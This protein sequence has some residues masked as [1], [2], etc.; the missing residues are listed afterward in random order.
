[1]ISGKLFF[2]FLLTLL[3]ALLL[4]PVETG[5]IATGALIAAV[6]FFFC[7]VLAKFREM[8]N[9]E[10]KLRVIKNLAI[11]SLAIFILGFASITLSIELTAISTHERAAAFGI[12]D[13]ASAPAMQKSVAAEDKSVAAEDRGTA[14]EASIIDAIWLVPENSSDCTVSFAGESLSFKP[15]KK[16]AKK[17]FFGLEKVFCPVKILPQQIPEKGLV[18]LK[19]G[20]SC[21]GTIRVFVRENGFE[22]Q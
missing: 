13:L 14:K 2:A 11:F 18:E 10:K 9:T 16:C 17:T 1:M 12:P 15:E 8:R 7:M 5:E 3:V 21:S 22:V 19:A 20:G 4:K 6:A